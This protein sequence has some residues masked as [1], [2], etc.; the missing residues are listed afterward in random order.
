MSSRDITGFEPT[1]H[2]VNVDSNNY[3]PHPPGPAPPHTNNNNHGQNVVDTGS[4]MSQHHG[5]H[6][7]EP[8]VFGD[9]G[10]VAQQQQQ[11][12]QHQQIHPSFNGPQNGR[13]TPEAQQ[14]PPPQM[15]TAPSG[16]EIQKSNRLRKACDS[17]SI[18]KVKVCDNHHGASTNKDDANI[19][20]L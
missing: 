16:G 1:G 20:C 7:P 4:P 14:G 13:H 3:H 17:C 5:G 10:Q 11:Q 19:F 12:P 9:I 2:G 15:Q 6:I 8:F 18:R